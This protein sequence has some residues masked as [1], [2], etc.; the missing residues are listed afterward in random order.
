MYAVIFTAEIGE[1][2]AQYTEMAELLRKRAI[3]VYGCIEFR[4]L[5][6]GK[7]E[8]AISYWRTLEDIAAWRGDAMHKKAQQLGA[9][10][11]Y[12]DYKVEVLRVQHAYQKS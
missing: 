3:E 12:A 6:E 2:D 8:I 1:L 9:E 4:A 11:W 5:T 7:Q 10:R